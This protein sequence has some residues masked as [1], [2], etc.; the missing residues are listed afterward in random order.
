MADLHGVYAW[1]RDTSYYYSLWSLA[2]FVGFI[3]LNHVLGELFFE[4]LSPTYRSL[5]RQKKIEWNCR[6]S[7]SLHASIVT[8]LSII[9]L[10]FDRTQWFEPIVTIS[11]PGCI[12]L[13]ISIGYMLADIIAMIAFQKGLQLYLF[14]VHHIIVAVCFTFLLA[15]RISPIYAIIRLTCEIST[16]FLNQRRDYRVHSLSTGVRS[17]F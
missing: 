9:S 7:S 10:V 13:A 6:V 2:S 3:C 17:R 4:W 1:P 8:V 16:P 11:R 12:A 14:T 15:Y 5:S